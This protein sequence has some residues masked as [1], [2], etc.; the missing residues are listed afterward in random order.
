MAVR[1]RLKNLAEQKA[2]GCMFVY[3]MLVI[4]QKI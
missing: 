4:Y 2:L 3:K 1:K